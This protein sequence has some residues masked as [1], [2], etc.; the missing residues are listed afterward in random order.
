MRH[1]R[2]YTI[3]AVG[4]RERDLQERDRVIDTPFT[5]FLLALFF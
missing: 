4:A 3:V 1:R 2:S 5:V